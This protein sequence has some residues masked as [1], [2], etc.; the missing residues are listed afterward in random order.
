MY[1]I[2]VYGTLKRG[3]YN[4]DRLCGAETMKF[5]GEGEVEDYSLFDTGYGYPCAMKVLGRKIK[6]EYFEVED[7]AFA[8]IQAMEYGAGFKDVLLP[9][10]SVMWAYP[11]EEIGEIYPQQIQVDDE[12]IK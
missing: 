1:K 11:Y 10:G 12:K 2:F 5:I 7:T 9:D 8:C 6:G 3:E 4:Y